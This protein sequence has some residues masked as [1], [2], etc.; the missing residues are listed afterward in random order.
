MR[1][2]ERVG[3]IKRVCGLRELTFDAPIRVSH[4]DVLRVAPFDGAPL[5][6]GAVVARCAWGYVALAIPDI[7]DGDIIYKATALGEH[8]FKPSTPPAPE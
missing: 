5:R 4:D 2:W 3:R 7:A 8:A 6:D 1:G